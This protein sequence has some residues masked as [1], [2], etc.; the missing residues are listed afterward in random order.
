MEKNIKNINFT[1]FSSVS[2]IIPCRNEERL[3]SKCLDSIIANDYPKDRLEILVV[4]GRSE[5]RTREI[6][7]EYA[8]QYSYLRILDNP[9]KITPVALNIGIKE[10]KGRIILMMGAHASY[11][12]DYIS[13]C[14]K[15]LSEYKADNVGGV[16]K[17]IL[18]KNSIIARS[19]AMVLSHPFGTG[20][21]Y[22]RKGSQKFRWVDTVF[23]GCY[24]REI[25]NKIGLYNE[26]LARNQ[27][28]EFNLRLKRAGGKILLAPDI[29][30]YYYPSFNFLGEFFYKNFKDGFWITYTLKFIKT[31]LCLRH[32]IPLI[33]ISSVLIIGLLGFFIPFFFWLF[34]FIISLYLV[35]S[36]YF[37]FKIFKKE[38]DI[39]FL[40]SVPLVF[41]ARHIGYGL[42]SVFGIFNI[43]KNYPSWL[44]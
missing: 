25:F 10:S 12:K 41:A 7:K 9:K 15:Y 5:D 16:T 36:F 4:E 30:N 43:G 22:F 44:K 20:D 42:G 13:K 18:S 37:S 31:P 38:K 17:T 27:D 23:G 26:N 8:K 3:I 19:I 21:S 14:V 35:I 39:R 24:R 32:Y 1:K 6:L 29:I 11:E 33:F 34:S 40:F 2:V 28:M